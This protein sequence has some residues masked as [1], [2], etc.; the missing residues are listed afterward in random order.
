MKIKIDEEENKM[1]KLLGMILA[2]AM[3]LLSLAGCKAGAPASSSSS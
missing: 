3:I 2:A 1:K